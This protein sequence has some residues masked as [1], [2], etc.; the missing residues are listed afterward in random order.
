MTVHSG[1][2]AVS[3]CERGGF[4]VSPVLR[5]AEAGRGG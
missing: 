1:E 3:A 2:R 5:Q 4:A